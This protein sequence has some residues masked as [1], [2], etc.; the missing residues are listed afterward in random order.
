MLLQK[1]GVI[2]LKKKLISDILRRRNSVESIANSSEGIQIIRFWISRFKCLVVLDDVDEMF[3]FEEMLGNIRNFVSGSRFVMTSRNVK[4]LSISAEE[5]KLYRVLE[6]SH[7]HSLQL[8]CKHAFKLDSPPSS[9]ET[10]SKDIVD[11]A[12]GLPLTLKVVGSLLFQEGEAIWIEKLRQLKEISEEKVVERL[13][14]SY[15][16]E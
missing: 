15:G 2:S 12:T 7:G 1:D 5:C 6:M 16:V 14:I 8:F 9:Y 10:L 3:E 4:V 11:V 13:T